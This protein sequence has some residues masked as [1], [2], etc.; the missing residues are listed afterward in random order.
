VLAGCHVLSGLGAYAA[1]RAG[2]GFVLCF[3]HAQH[4]LIMGRLQLCIV[5]ALL[6]WPI[7][8]LERALSCRDPRRG[9]ETTLF[10][11]VLLG[12]LVLAHPGFGYWACA[13]TGLY[14]LSRLA[15]TGWPVGWPRVGLLL[16]VL[17]A[18]LAVGAA[19]VLP[20][21]LDKVYTGLSNSEYSHVGTPDPRWWHVLVWSNFRFWLWPPSPAEFNWY[22]GYL[23]L[24]LMGIALAGLVAGARHWG[25]HRS[26][27]AVAAAV[28]LLGSLVM[29]FG[30]RTALV[31]LLPNSEI[32]GAGRYLLFV[33]FFL[34]LCAGHGVR[35]LQVRSRRRGGAWQRVVGLATL[36]LVADLGPTTFQ[37][38]YRDP[39]SRIDPANVSFEFYESLFAESRA[40]EERGELPGYRVVWAAAD[41][42]R[43]HGTGLL[44]F[45]A[46]TPVPD[47]PHPGEL[48]SVF[49]FVR[50]LIRLVDMS[51]APN[52]VADDSQ[53]NVDP[54]VYEGLTLLNVR[55]LLARSA[56]GRTLGLQ[57]PDPSPIHVSSLLSPP[58][59]GHAA[60]LSKMLH[61][62][63][64]RLL[65]KSDPRDVAGITHVISL[66]EGMGVDPQARTCRTFFVDGLDADVE[67]GTDVG[68]TVLRHTVRAQRVDLRVRTASRCFARLAYGHYPY[69]EILVDGARV[70]PRVSSAG[71]VIIELDAG[72]HDILLLPRM[73][74]LRASLL[75]SSLLIVLGS[76]ACYIRSRR[77]PRL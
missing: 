48:H 75:W 30:Y 62:D 3:W 73:S 13:F 72:E 1:A 60:A 12:V 45:N 76:T 66:L 32:L 4:V 2:L 8:A 38:P 20:M 51:I 67:L 25:A 40:Y 34:A 70:Q 11:G 35:F 6:P 55:Y 58:P 57:L 71:F 19:L 26:P 69:V 14:G 47:G 39:L 22:G 29:V 33:T 42:N 28:C 18:G 16:L 9:L 7:W 46:R 64:D 49:R 23:G 74:I 36:V 37:H 27:G 17:A 77:S 44:Y 61:M 63:L 15:V 24:S 56:S 65:S 59:Q 53:L 5:Y 54:T 52:L 21:W 68:V 31:R 10:G 43:Y 41:M 50:P